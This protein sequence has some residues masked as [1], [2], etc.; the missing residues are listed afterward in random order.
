[1]QQF[2]TSYNNGVLNFQRR[3]DNNRPNWEWKRT[4]KFNDQHRVDPWRSY[5]N[6]GDNRLMGSVQ[7]VSV[8]G[9]KNG[10]DGS[11]KTS[12]PEF[13]GGHISG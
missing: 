11:K 3:G 4:S 10:P 12:H 5:S 8:Q 7:K 13:K 1:M 2:T 6:S 9:E